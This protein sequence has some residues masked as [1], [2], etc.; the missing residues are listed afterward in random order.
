VRAACIIGISR[1]SKTRLEVLRKPVLVRGLTVAHRALHGLNDGLVEGPSVRA[2]CAEEQGPG[3]SNFEASLTMRTE[4]DSSRKE[5]TMTIKI[6]RLGY[7]A[8]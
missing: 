8:G 3:D 2:G 6:E 4:A 1:L 5:L 7:A